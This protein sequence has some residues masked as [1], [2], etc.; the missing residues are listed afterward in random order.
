MFHK[1]N[2][3]PTCVAA[4]SVIRKKLS[5]TSNKVDFTKRKENINPIPRL[6]KQA[7][8]ANQHLLSGH[9]SAGMLLW[10]PKTQ[11]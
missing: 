3:T 8:Y 11:K 5:K 6:A 2:I 9:S 10:S 4:N 7:V 1:R